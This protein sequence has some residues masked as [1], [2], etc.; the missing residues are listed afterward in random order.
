M[1]KP[2]IIYCRRSTKKSA[3]EDAQRNSID[4]Q[5]SLLRKFASDNNS[6]VID[7][8]V[9]EASGTDDD[10]P[11]FAKALQEA[12]DKDAYLLVL[13][14]DRLSRSLSS[15]KMLETHLGRIRSPQTS[16]TENDFVTFSLLLVLAANEQKTLSARVKETM[17]HLKERD[18]SIKFG[19]PRIVETAYQPGLEVRQRNAA[20]FNARIQSLLLE[21]DATGKYPT[22]KS[23]AAR[24]NELGF[25][26]R[27]GKKF[28]PATVRHI[29]N[30]Q[31]AA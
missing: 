7:V 12:V 5:T 21:L 9:E 14:I 19:N 4:V 29:Q 16:W 15:F 31:A 20:Q 18:P 24:L 28:H 30:Y 6:P 1:I 13:R 22:L 11:V 25:T 10:R 2:S 8:Y 23:K 3:T 17:R 27:T 26:T